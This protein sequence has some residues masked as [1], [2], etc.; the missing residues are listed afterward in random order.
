MFHVE[1]LR[2]KGAPKKPGFGAREEKPSLGC[3]GRLRFAWFT[4]HRRLYPSKTALQKRVFPQPGKDSALQVIHS[5]TSPSR[6]GTAL[7]SLH[8]PARKNRKFSTDSRNFAPP[9]HMD[10]ARSQIVWHQRVILFLANSLP[11]AFHNFVAFS[12]SQAAIPSA[13]PTVTLKSHGQDTRHRQSK[14]R[15]W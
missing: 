8:T 7:E 13:P 10:N 14:R 12:T 5:Q 15:S 4:A 1:R 11:P 3:E 9:R 6:I 2:R